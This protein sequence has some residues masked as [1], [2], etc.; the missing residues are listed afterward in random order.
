[1]ALTDAVRWVVSDIGDAIVAG[2]VE[3]TA[4]IVADALAERDAVRASLEP[5]TWEV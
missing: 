3:H 4:A 5:Y 2:A 1:M